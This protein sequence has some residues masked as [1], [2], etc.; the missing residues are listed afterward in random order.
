[1]AKNFYKNM[2]EIYDTLI[3]SGSNGSEKI[4]K[5]TFLNEFVK[6]NGLNIG[7][8]RRKFDEAVDIGVIK[9][10]GVDEQGNDLIV[11]NY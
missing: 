5:I 6:Q 1:M 7:T 4:K 11:V 10:V 8:G 9:Y 3:S 2:K